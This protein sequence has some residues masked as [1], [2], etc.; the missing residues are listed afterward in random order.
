VTTGGTRAGRQAGLLVPLFSCP[1]TRSWGI[2]EFGDLIPLAAWMRQAGLRLLQL[3]P[4]NEL[5]PGQTSPY[6]ATSAMAL[7]PIFITV[8]AVPDFQAAGGEGVLDDL[9]RRVLTRAKTATRV[10][11]RR[12]RVVKTAALRSAFEWFFENQWTRDSARAGE[13]RR[14][15]EEQRW[16]LDD[17]ALFRALLHHAGGRE[18]REWPEGARDRRPESIAEARRDHRQEILFRQYLQWIAHC[19]WR[20]ARSAACEIRVY[21]DFP[22]GVAADSADVWAHQDLFRFDGTIGAPPDAFSDEGQNWRLPMYRWDAIAAGRFEWFTRRA[23]RAADL[24][25]G[26]RV[27]HVVGL[28]R[29]WMFPLDDRAPRFVPAE[30]ADQIV[31]GEAVLRALLACG[32]DVVAEDLG[33]IPEF[34][35]AAL[36]AL[37]I[38]GYKVL[39]WEREWDTP[40]FPFRH[41]RD[42][43]ACS[44]A[45]TGTHDTDALAEWWN[46]LDLSQRAALLTVCGCAGPDPAALF[47]PAVRDGLLEALYGSG[48]D[49]LV[50]PIQDVFGWTDRIN[51]P[52]Q[53]DE[54]NWTWKLPWTVDVLDTQPEAVERAQTLSAWGSTHRRLT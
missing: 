16:W 28:F 2:G 4:L 39:R 54:I 14:F 20:D 45:T 17:Y 5:A 11:Y 34:V 32:A 6:S 43:P 50:L 46:L 7:D 49:L 12:V 53:V 30:P 15:I 38:P 29:T 27:D 52:A 8:P 37:E 1:S 25:D 36:S 48:S 13:L 42:Y 18:W 21:G 3:L 44:L 40:G 22:F 35:R 19:Q 33:T 9:S 23:R 41:P 51:V 10:D 47:G 26:Y 24:F 31:Q